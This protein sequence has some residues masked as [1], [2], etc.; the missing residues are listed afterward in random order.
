VSINPGLTGG[1]ASAI[2]TLNCTTYNPD[3]GGY[4][5]AT[6]DVFM[7]AELKGFGDDFYTAGGV[8]T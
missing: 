8:Y 1:T 4:D 6:V 5:S 7:T 3:T 2:V